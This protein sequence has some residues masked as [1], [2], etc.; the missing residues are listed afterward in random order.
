ME[1]FLNEQQWNAVTKAIKELSRDDSPSACWHYTTL[2]ALNAIIKDSLE[3]VNHF[4]VNYF[5]TATFWASNIRYLNDEQEFRDGILKLSEYEEKDIVDTC[6]DNVYLISFCGDGDLLSQW[7][8]Y[9]K[10]SGIAVKFNLNYVRYKYWKEIEQKLE[11]HDD[12]L[13]TIAGVEPKRK[14]DEQTRPIKVKYKDEEKVKYYGK[15]KDMSEISGV[16][17]L[18]SNLFVPFCK[19]SGFS[20]EN[21]SRL[22]FYAHQF[23]VYKIGNRVTVPD[24]VYNL[25]KSTV[26]PAL[27]VHM[28]VDDT[29][30]LIDQI[31]V[32]PGY[33]QNLVFNAL[34]HMFDRSHYHFF[35]IK[36]KI[37]EDDKKDGDNKSLPLEEFLKCKSDFLVHRVD[38]KTQNDKTQTRLA[39]KCE[40]GIVIMKSSIPFRG[41]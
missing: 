32:G 39:Y 22:V 15:L 4:K 14:D 11:S 19:H 16:P 10:E 2:S 27:Q 8:Y 41:D 12:P 9:G 1:N 37:P 6:M 34:I 28:E 7:K 33:N 38:I 31:V 23:G 24:I 18:I 3:K 20:E 35:D 29:R 13:I 40:N 21:E 5:N 36:D 26:K 30:N 17:S 25:G